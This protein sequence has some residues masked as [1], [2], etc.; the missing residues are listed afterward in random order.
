MFIGGKQIGY[1]CLKILLKNGII[2][3][4]VIA[5]TDD[6]GD[7]PWHDSVANLAKKNNLSLTTA[8]MLK[9]K[10]L[11]AKI[12]QIKPEII[13]CIGSTAYIPESILSSAK[14]GTINI[15]PA[16][17]PKYRGRY[18]TVHAIFNGEKTTGVTLHWMNDRIDAGPIIMQEKFPILPEDTGK[19]VYNKFTK[20]G[21]KLFSKFLKKYLM[22]MS[23][24]AKNQNEKQATYY[25][26]GL[27][28]NG[29][30]D[31]NWSGKK[32]YNFIRAMTFEPFPPVT[33]K[34]G[35][36]TMIIID[37]KYIKDIK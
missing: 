25:P 37:E 1:E 17:L 26:K 11:K 19:T 34:I 24:P 18:S 12:M 32:I 23:I 14:I 22:K 13:F 2:P 7:M 30:I 20:T 9:S 6:K 31:W 15:H 21:V 27:P 10:A 28:N 35:K 29:N 16:L 8:D 5:N 33:F 3:S 36:K 4:L